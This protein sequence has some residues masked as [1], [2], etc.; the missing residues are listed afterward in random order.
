MSDTDPYAAPAVEESRPEVLAPV[1][2]PAET[3]PAAPVTDE[4]AVPSGSIKD[5]LAWVAGDRT[6][7]QAALKVEN[8][9]AKRKTLITELTEIIK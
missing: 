8:A 9:G 7:A 4:S 5:I 6:R 3:A 2:V 1:A